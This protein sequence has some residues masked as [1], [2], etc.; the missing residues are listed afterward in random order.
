[1]IELTSMRAAILSGNKAALSLNKHHQGISFLTASIFDLLAELPLDQIAGVSMVI[2]GTEGETKKLCDGIMGQFKQWPYR[3]NRPRGMG[4]HR[5]D[6]IQIADML[7]GAARHRVAGK[8]PDYLA[9][10]TAKFRL[11]EAK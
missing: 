10:L 1:V 6:G 8:S 2:D 9:P 11:K 5:C 3:P 7:A 4:S